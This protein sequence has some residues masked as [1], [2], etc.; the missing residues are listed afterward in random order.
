MKLYYEEEQWFHGESYDISWGFHNSFLSKTSRA[1]IFQ[2]EVSN[3]TS[4]TIPLIGILTSDSSKAEFSGN[5]AAF[6]R[7]QLSLQKKGAVSFVFS[8]NGFDRFG[9][10]GFLFDFQSQSWQKAKFPL[11]SVVYNRIPFRKHEMSKQVSQLFDTLSFLK[12]PFFNG[13]FFDKSSTFEAMS[14]NK[15]LLPHL[16]ITKKLKGAESF[17]E[18]TRSQK[19][20]YVK[21]NNGK[22]GK[23]IFLVEERI[24]RKWNV[25]T[26]SNS[27][28]E[29]S[30]QQVIHNWITPLLNRDYLVQEAIE[31]LKWN[32]SRFD[33]RLL[34]HRKGAD[35]FILSGV[36]VR[37]SGEQQVTTH[38]PTGGQI[39]PFQSLPFHQKDFVLLKSI[40]S[41][42]G[43]ALKTYFRNIGEFSMDIGKSANGH[44][45]IFEVNSKPMVFDEQHIRKQGL[46][47]L[48]QLLIYEANKSA[49][50]S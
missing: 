30:L 35:T 45:Y 6:K 38:V 43:I 7:L 48:S 25:L 40:A 42:T 4:K 29:N 41:L 34:V 50:P 12:I 22:K 3:K 10:N 8:P 16:P 1:G 47:N 11:P 2:I 31:P 24:D 49:P 19:R 14:Q 20:V 23:G 18:M 37:Q 33:Y 17:W 9:I 32:G 36:G 28:V 27:Y 26:T 44:L 5:Q 39:I 46:E 13:G 15:Q 21:P